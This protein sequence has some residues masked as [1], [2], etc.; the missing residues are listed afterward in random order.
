MKAAIW[1][2]RGERMIVDDVQLRELGDHDL[3]MRVS[4]ASICMTDVIDSRPRGPLADQAHPVPIPMILGH[5]SVGIVEEVGR[6]VTLTK[7]GDRVIAAA[8][9]LCNRCYY[10]LRGRPEQCA[11][12]GNRVLDARGRMSDGREVCAA[13]N[14]GAFAELAIV[15]EMQIAPIETKVSDDELAV[16]SIMLSAGLGGA[17]I[18]APLEEG[19]TAAVFGCGMTGLGYVQGARVAGA[20]RI[21]AVDPIEER[22]ELALRLGATHGIDP[23]DGDVVDQIRSFEADMGGFEG[24]GVEYTYEAT[25]DE[26]AIEQAFAVT[27]GSGHVVMASVP[28]NI[29]ATVTLGAAD[30]AM[31]G[32]T[33]HSSQHGG[34]NLL[35]DFPRFVRLIE[36]GKVD[37]RALVTKH[38]ALDELNEALDEIE[39][40]EV[41]GA[42]MRL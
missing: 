1:P 26:T 33:L 30:L 39:R 36:D 41:V 14:I 19:S 29:G 9:T 15:P 12:I 38:Y 10:C 22:R 40:Y 20:S 31:V 16:L 25:G 34:I 37:A 11:E 2:A 13:G 32:R 8:T 21:Y 18:S 27:R 35:R 42:I 6:C 7:P 3:L 28:W 24:R 23:A 4:A 5:G 17:L